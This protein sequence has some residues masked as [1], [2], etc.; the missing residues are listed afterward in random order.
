MSSKKLIKSGYKKTKLGWI[1]EDWE[2]EKIGNS[3]DCIAGGTPSTKVAE[4]WG[5]DIK[6]MKSG[7][8]NLK[9][10]FEV[11]GRITKLGLDNSST[12]LLPRNS[13]LIALAGQGKTR[14]KVAISKVE[15]CTNQS[16]AAIICNKNLID[17]KYLFYNIDSRYEEIRKMSTGDGGRGGL[18]LSIIKNIKIPLAPLPEQKKIAKI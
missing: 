10:V 3:A 17:Y 18:N 11:E 12:R 7:E 6:W 5:G 4:Y 9:E 1:P 15:L 2:V 13:V 8:I 16:V 14:G